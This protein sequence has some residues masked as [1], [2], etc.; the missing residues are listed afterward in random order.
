MGIT[1]LPRTWR[2]IFPSISAKAGITETNIFEISVGC[3]LERENDCSA[4]HFTPF[5]GVAE[6]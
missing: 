2:S 3:G 4:G 6:S 1:R 5:L